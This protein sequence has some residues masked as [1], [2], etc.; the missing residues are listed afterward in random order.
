MTHSPATGTGPD[1]T[2]DALR[3]HLDTHLHPAARALLR[4]VLDD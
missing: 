1:T 3:D 4:L 2:P